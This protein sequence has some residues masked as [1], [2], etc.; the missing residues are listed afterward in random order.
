MLAGHFAGMV[1]GREELASGWEHDLAEA[2]R[3]LSAATD[4]QEATDQHGF[5]QPGSAG[6]KE[7][8]ATVETQM[9]LR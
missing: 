8:E 2:Q 6:T 5:S 4:G 3:D 7:G 9:K 1:M